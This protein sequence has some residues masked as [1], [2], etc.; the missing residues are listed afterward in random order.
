MRL[1]I[2]DDEHYIVNYM[3]SL[4]EEHLSSD[5]EIYKC[6]SGVDALELLETVKIDLMLLDINMPGLSGLEVAPKALELLPDC[7]IIFLT[8]YDNFEYI[9]E[10]NKSNHTR[11]LLKTE[12]DEM[13]LEEVEHTVKEI[14]E[15]AKK[16]HLISEAQQKTILLSHLLQQNILKGILAGHKTDNLKTELELAGS[17]FVLD[18]QRP[19][20][21]MYTQIHHKTLSESSIN[22]STYTLQYLQ[23]I[24]RLLVEKF[25]F[26][27]LDMGKGTMFW[28]FQPNVSFP[29]EFSFLKTIA[30]DFGDYCTSTLH[31]QIT[32]VLYPDPSSWDD[33]CNHFH[34]MQQYAESS[35]SAVPLIYS[36]VNILEDDVSRAVFASSDFTVDRTFV[37]RQFQ[38][39]SFYLYQANEEEYCQ[40]LK[41]LRSKCEKLK[42]MHDIGAIRIY[43]SISLMLLNYID[44]Y[45]LQEKIVSQ[46]A[47]YP[48]YYI[49]NFSSWQDAFQYLETLSL[50]IFNILSSK[51]TDKNELLVNKIKAYIDEHLAESLTLT[52]ISRLVNYNETYVSRLF[53]QLTGM[54][55]SEYIS[56]E[57]I[58]KAEHLLSST[59]EPIQNIAAST[60]FDTAQYFSIVFK[61]TTGISPSE[62]RRTHQ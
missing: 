18:L 23:L 60:G 57:R 30:N 44:L 22:N 48:L 17:D 2:V 16:L 42:S 21:L 39:L 10:S 12:S 14:E 61:K 13:I 4:M 33:V 7:R 37:D 36:S 53:K 20:Y 51:K 29:S 49:Q 35:I 62:Y 27:M 43:N 56:H 5:L 24:R 47:L 25:T 26:S 58:Q 52:T 50:H 41:D 6:Y 40:I 15:E 38:E 59:T 32:T 28:F 54:G 45:H 9:Y 8:A 46:I 19:V 11:Y 31:R 3:A 55:L 1:L 34:V